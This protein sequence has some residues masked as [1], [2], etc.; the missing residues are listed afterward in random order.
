MKYILLAIS[1]IYSEI[2]SGQHVSADLSKPDSVCLS[3]II[4]NCTGS[5]EWRIKNGYIE[6]CNNNYV[7]RLVD[8]T[9]L[10]V[11]LKERNH[12]PFAGKFSV[13]AHYKVQDGFFSKSACGKIYPLNYYPL[14]KVFRS[15]SNFINALK[16][17]NDKDLPITSENDRTTL[18]NILYNKYVRLSGDI[19]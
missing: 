14:K 9:G 2:I 8:T 10:F 4:K 11:Y 12:H 3:T 19:D 5:K 15:N 17:V 6:R 13:F 16:K 7:Y 1:F 18:I